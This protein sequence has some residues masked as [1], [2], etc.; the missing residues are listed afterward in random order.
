[1]PDRFETA[2][3]LFDLADQVAL[4]SI[5]LFQYR[6]AVQQDLAVAKVRKLREQE[7]QLDAVTTELRAAA[8]KAVTDD[9]AGALA[10]VTAATVKAQ[11]VITRI[12]KIEQAIKVAT[13][14]VALAV[15]V[16][17][18]NLVAIGK[19]AGSLM[20]ATDEAKA[21]NAAAREAAVA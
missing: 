19:A 9:V 14:V 8:V 2:T 17:D 18:G 5:R 3:A 21:G 11:K 6:L 1:M 16:L 20:K 12:A 15:S 10:E 4:V 13:A 7:D